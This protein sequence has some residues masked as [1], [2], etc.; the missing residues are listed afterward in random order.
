MTTL[1]VSDLAPYEGKMTDAEKI[2][3]HTLVR[4]GSAYV[5]GRQD[6]GESGQD[7]GFS[8]DF[9][10]AYA[11]AQHITG[12][13]FGPLQ[14]AFHEWHDTGRLLV[15]QPGTRRIIQI[16]AQAWKG[17]TKVEAHLTV[18]AGTQYSLPN[19]Y[20]LVRKVAAPQCQCCVD[21]ECECVAEDD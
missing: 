1:V 12:G 9:G 20:G 21:N 18:W 8:L 16:A 2:E 6:A 11:M 13:Y 4:V 10:K 3:W 17:T 19:W 7:T 15:V 14:S 5:W